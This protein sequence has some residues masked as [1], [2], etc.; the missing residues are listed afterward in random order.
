M[1]SVLQHAA[2]GHAARRIDLSRCEYEIAQ[3]QQ[4]LIDKD[5]EL[6]IYLQVAASFRKGQQPRSS[7]RQQQQQ[8][9]LEREV[10]ELRGECAF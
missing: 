5:L 7:S 4:Q 10:R 1:C 3:L 9:C 2:L 8:L 6:N